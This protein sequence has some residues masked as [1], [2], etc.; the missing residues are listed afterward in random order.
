MLVCAKMV[1]LSVGIAATGA[2]VS[3]SSRCISNCSNCK[4]QFRPAAGQCGESVCNDSKYVHQWAARMH[5]FIS[6]LDSS[7]MQGE[8]Q[9]LR[10]IHFPRRRDWTILVQIL[11]ALPTQ[12]IH[13]NTCTKWL[14]EP[15]N[16]SRISCTIVQQQQNVEES[17]RNRI[18]KNLATILPCKGCPELTH[19]PWRIWKIEMDLTTWTFIS[20]P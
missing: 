13:L 15:E 3:R 17:H 11:V 2:N 7:S 14:R 16:N 4:Q 1:M 20:R 8:D 5:S 19:A 12:C 9:E 18:R 10:T 6:P